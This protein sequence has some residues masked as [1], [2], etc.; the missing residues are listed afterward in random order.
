GRPAEGRPAEGR[1]AEGRLEGRRADPMA[2]RA[3]AHP[4]R[5]RLLDLL[6]SED[7]ATA[8][9]CAEVLGESV[10]SCSYHLGMLA[11]YGYI[12]L[13]PGQ[14]GREKPWRVAS[15]RQDLSAEG[16][17]EPGVLAAQAATE[18]FLDHELARIK[19]RLRRRDLEPAE[20]R[21]AG[22]VSGTTTWLTAGEL[23]EIKD[24]LIGIA[25]RYAGRAEDPASRPAG[26]REARIFTVTSVAP[27]LPSPR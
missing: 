6:A 27:P 5:W 1:P 2:L 4:V 20:W 15:L 3:L 9:R 13:V 23:R 8:T 26:A 14:A 12:E 7:S 19:D 18:V 11:K 25:Q 21:E 24:Q 16:L 17:D 22:H 10:A